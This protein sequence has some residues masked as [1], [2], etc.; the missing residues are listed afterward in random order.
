MKKTINK[1]TIEGRVYQFDLEVKKVQNTESENYGKD[2]ISGTLEVA[3][4]EDGLNVV[5][6][7]YT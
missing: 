1:E 3:V 4:D 7:H 6:V 5:P 2:F